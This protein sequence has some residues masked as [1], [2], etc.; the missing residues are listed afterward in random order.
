MDKTKKSVGIIYLILNLVD[1]KMYIGQTTRTLEDRLAEHRSTKKT[2]IA[3]AFRKYGEENFL[4]VIIEYCHSLEQ[5]NER[6][7]FYI[8]LLN[9]IAPNGYNLTDGG[10]NNGHLSEE[11]K[12]KLSRRHTG[13]KL[14]SE[15]CK[16]I[17]LAKKGIHLSAEVRAKMSA[18]RKGR[19][20]SENARAKLLERNEENKKQIVCLEDK[21]IFQSISDAAEYY[22]ISSGAIS[23]TCN[24]GRN[25]AGGIHF[26]FLEDWLASDEKTRVN[27]LAKQP[28]RR[29]RVICI[30]SKEIFS[31]IREA[32][33]KYGIDH[34]NIMRACGK[35][36]RTAG[37]YHWKFV[38]E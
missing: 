11:T 24:G 27:L 2:A 7:K 28:H 4:S 16:K 30:E 19:P 23:S 35:S 21:K 32:A 38:D 12:T 15:T 25:T 36:T 31:S 5:L 34:K 1:G 17:S 29:K 10:K 3:N 26:M 14:S 20:I 18:S 9:T 22:K 6:E 8:A 13:K 33:K 37:N